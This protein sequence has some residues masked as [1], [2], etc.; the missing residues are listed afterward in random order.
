M[1][2]TSNEAD[3]HTDGELAENSHVEES[4]NTNKQTS[5]FCSN[6]SQVKYKYAS[7]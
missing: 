3:L 4:F 5:A 6:E 1:L 2:Y 7:K